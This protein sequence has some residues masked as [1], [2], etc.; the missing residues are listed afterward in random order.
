MGI[1]DNRAAS[2]ARN[3]VSGIPVLL[4]PFEPWIQ[5]QDNFFLQNNKEINSKYNSLQKI[6]NYLVVVVFGFC[7]CVCVCGGGGGLTNFVINLRS[8]N[9]FF[10]IIL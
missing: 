8:Y 2:K 7:V 4:V 5:I 10:S 3:S 1:P 6:I 9:T